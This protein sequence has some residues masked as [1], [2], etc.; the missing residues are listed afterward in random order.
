MLEVLVAIASVTFTPLTV[1]LPFASIAVV[2]VTLPS[3]SV[4]TNLTPLSSK[5]CVVEFVPPCSTKAPFAPLPV[6]RLVVIPSAVTVVELPV[7]TSLATIPLAVK[8]AVLSAVTVPSV[9]VSLDL[10]T[11]P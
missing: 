11:V 3:A 2:P 9:A 10:A 4:V 5:V 8:V 6:I 1:R 7:T